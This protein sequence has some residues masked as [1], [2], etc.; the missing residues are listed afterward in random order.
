MEA[1]IFLAEKRDGSKKG[2]Q[3]YNGKPAREWLSWEE[4]ASPT[5]SQEGI[6]LMVTIDSKENRDVMCINAPNAFI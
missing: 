1:L 2:R 6:N 5:V 4:S 3:V